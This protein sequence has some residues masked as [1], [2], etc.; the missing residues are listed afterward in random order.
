MRH[1]FLIGAPKCGTTALW[2]ALRQH[3][4]IAVPELPGIRAKET[5]FF[6]DEETWA[7]GQDWY[8]GLY[9]EVGDRWALDATTNL[10][11]APGWAEAVPRIW[12][13]RREVRVIYVVRDPVERVR[14]ETTHWL[15]EGYLDE[16]LDRGVRPF[17][18]ATSNYWYQLRSWEMYFGREAIRVFRYAD[19]RA[20]V[21]G[22]ARS[23]FRFLGLDAGVPLEP[24][25]R[26]NDSADYLKMLVA[27]R[28]RGAGLPVDPSAEAPGVPFD[29]FVDRTMRGLGS[30]VLARLFTEVLREVRA[31]IVP[32][33]AVV[34]KLHAELDADL[35]RFAEVWGIDP[36]QAG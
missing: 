7:R 11:K 29:E 36:W 31:A 35:A 17:S 1:L 15:A 28:C 32:G 24:V 23:V 5:T 10:S 26:R 34:R 27:R 20:D 16:G 12:R 3:P 9:G 18:V 22:T 13:L 6:T 4:D 14:S 2:W 33:E 25:G 19:L 21:L 8:D 30:P